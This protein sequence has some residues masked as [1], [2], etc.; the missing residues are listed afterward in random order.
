MQGGLLPIF[1]GFNIPAP[2][3]NTAIITTGVTNILTTRTTLTAITPTVSASLYIAVVLATAS[4]FN[5]THT[6]SGTKNTYGMEQSQ[7]LSAGDAFFW[8]WP[9]FPG[10]TYN[11]EVETNGIISMLFV[12]ELQ[13]GVMT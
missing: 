2:G 7:A 3:A 4:I 13:A 8:T 6:Y 11:F 12:G 9:V 1:A 10:S 5:I